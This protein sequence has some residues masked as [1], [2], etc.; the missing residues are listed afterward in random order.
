VKQEN[1]IGGRVSRAAL[2][3]VIVGALVQILMSAYY[4]SQAHA[5]RPRSLP[6]GF[7]AT[8]EATAQVRATIEAG[9]RFAARPYLTAAALTA[10][11]EDKTVYGGVDVSATPHL[12]V[13]SAAGPSAATAMRAVFTTV[14]QQ[15]TAAQ[16][17]RLITAGRPVP[18]DVLRRLTTPPAVTDVVPL[19]ADDGAG[20]SIGLLVQCLTLGASVAAIGLGRLR[21]L[22]RP[23]LRRGFGHLALLLAYGA[24]SAGAVLAAAHLFGVIPDGAAGRMFGTFFLVSLATTGSVAGL[25]ALIGPAGTFLGTAYFLFGLPVS[26][27]TV[28]P[29]FLPTAGRV[30]GQALP[31]GAGA[32]LVRDSLY[33]PGASIAAPATVL[34]LY[35]GVGIL[36]VLVTNALGN[37]SKRDSLL[38]HPHVGVPAETGD[39]SV[40]RQRGPVAEAVGTR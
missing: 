21:P 22:T 8:T 13:A 24:A 31:T 17:D 36:L 19:P 5:P 25:I 40:P 30:F 38:E 28:L 16:V 18:P 12:Y 35:A 39:L 23:S 34:G 29:D 7:V 15:Q 37:R 1:R 3:L 26:G 14:V 27:A 20:T 4:L 33:F 9:D 2:W 10:A 6:V 11:I 32:T